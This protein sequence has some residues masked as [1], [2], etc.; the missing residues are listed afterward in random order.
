MVWNLDKDWTLLII[1]LLAIFFFFIRKTLLKWSIRGW[2]VLITNTTPKTEKEN[3]IHQNIPPP[4]QDKKCFLH[5][6]PITSFQLLT[7]MEKGNP[8][9]SLWVDAHSED[10]AFSKIICLLAISPHIFSCC[11][12]ILFCQIAAQISS[13]SRCKF[14][15]YLF[16]CYLLVEIMWPT[17]SQKSCK[18]TAWSDAD[19][20]FGWS[21]SYCSSWATSLWDPTCG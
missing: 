1:C 15:T 19:N 12:N 9:N 3:I 8:L 21:N 13:S 10:F 17:D 6:L 16:C 5:Y 4:L 7:I 18:V 11:A 14:I 20:Y 2:V